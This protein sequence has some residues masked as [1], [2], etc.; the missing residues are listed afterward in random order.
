MTQTTIGNDDFNNSNLFKNHYLRD[1]IKELDDW[2]CDHEAR[3]ALSK[4]T[5][6]WNGE[7]SAIESYSEG[8]LL[9]SW[10]DKVLEQ[11]GYDTFGETPL[12]NSNGR[13]DRLL[14]RS[15]Q[16][17]Q[18]AAEQ[19]KGGNETAVFSQASAILEAKTWDTDFSSEFQEERRYGNASEQIKYYLDYTPDRAKWGILTNGRKW[20]LHWTGATSAN[21]FYEIDLPELIEK[22]DVESFKYFYAFFRA[23][24]FQETRSGSFLDK[25]RNESQKAA[26]SRGEDLQDDVFTALRLI[27]SELVEYH[28]ITP[29]ADSQDDPDVDLDLVKEESLIV[30]YRLMFM[31]Y[32]EAEGLIEPSGGGAREKYD[33]FF[34]IEALRADVFHTI[35]DG[36]TFSHYSTL[37]T[38]LWAQLCDLFQIIDRG[39][40]ELGIRAYDGELFDTSKPELLV[41]DAISD[42]AIAEVIYLIGTTESKSGDEKLQADYRDFNPRHLGSIYEGLLEHRF[43]IAKEPRV[44]VSQEDGQVWKSAAEVDT[45]ANSGTIVERVSE[46]ELY[47]INDD[48]KRKSEG[49]YYTPDVVVD[50]II[51]ESVEPLITEIKTEMGDEDSLNISDKEAFETFYSRVLELNIVDPAMGSGHFL[52]GVLDYLTGEVMDVAREVETVKKEA[53][54]RREIAKECI[55]GV[56]VNEMAV[57]LAK[58][59]LWLKTLAADLP[60]AFVDHHLRHGN[61]LVGTRITEALAVDTQTTFDAGF[62]ETRREVLADVMGSMTELLAIENE[63]L[64]DVE[65]MKEIHDEVRT[66]PLYRRLQSV[67]DVRVADQFG[68][69]IPET[70]YETLATAVE[71]QE[72]W[73]QKVTNTEW[74]QAAK[75]KTDSELS[76]HWDLEFMEVFFD[77]DGRERQNPGFDA[78]IGNPPYAKI[79]SER[80]EAL[81]SDVTTDLYVQFIAHAQGIVRENGVV[82]FIT[83]T[84]WETGPDYIGT[85][86][87]LLYDGTLRHLVNLPYDVF[88]DAYVDTAIFVWE[89]NDE[90]ETCEAA[91]LSGTRIDPIYA[92]ESLSTDEYALADWREV[93]IV[94]VDNHWISLYNRVGDAKTVRDVTESTRGVLVTDEAESSPNADTQIYYGDGSYQRYES[95]GPTTTVEYDKLKERPSKEYFE[96]DRVLI[97]RLVSRSDRLL[98]TFASDN[99]VTDKN[100]YVFKSESLKESNEIDQPTLDQTNTGSRRLDEQFL[101]AILNSRF[102]SWWQ[103]NVEMSASKDDFRQVTLGGLRD[104]PLPPIQDWGESGDAK[105][106]DLT[107]YIENGENKADLIESTSTENGATPDTRATIAAAVDKLIDMQTQRLNL[108]LSLDDHLGDYT[109]EMQLS[110]LGLVQ[111]AEGVVDSPLTRTVDGEKL[112][113]TAANVREEHSGTVTLT[114]EIEQQSEDANRGEYDALGEFDALQITDLSED[115]IELLSTYVPHAVENPDSVRKFRTNATQTITLLDRLQDYL[116]FPKVNKVETGLE[117]YLKI[118][119]RAADLDASIRRAD[120]LIDELVYDLY[121]V[122]QKEREIIERGS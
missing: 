33:Q 63:T 121:G 100:V 103:F 48:Q 19:R 36:N 1:P 82:S 67:A 57:E 77:T 25:I 52:T 112:R 61:S 42:R 96:G 3:Q 90:G 102:L 28:D 18:Q 27:G 43:E 22:G 11:L 78:V 65:S 21:T 29:K 74:F 45:E 84:S 10:I 73:E 106:S 2:D 69:D 115:E 120:T 107:A 94:V 7:Q 17:R 119:E 80:A 71:D 55:F 9:K 34:S 83:P 81:N 66:D 50:H 64:E 12:P 72:T 114:V 97:R 38:Q 95:I 47:V 91:D 31:F 54:V 98:G 62:E 14:Y 70:A 88:E 68:V 89:A 93:E 105:Q 5:S 53:S 60:L 56:D 37:S 117:T 24:A 16:I 75:T 49:A 26:R 109:A 35:E 59:S 111:P 46:G 20:R 122:T 104:L 110:D 99:F 40:D 85:R 44:A 79:P 51:S 39:G 58:V 6:L 4:L 87:N 113:L 92:I 108:N 118:K 23:K 15:P 30:L 86:E 116:L 13:V 41:R 32:A 8:E 101:L 76:F